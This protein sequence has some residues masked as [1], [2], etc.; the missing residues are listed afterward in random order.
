MI[1]TVATEPE[2]NPTAVTSFKL[3]AMIGTWGV[4]YHQGQRSRPHLKAGHM[5]A[6]DQRDQKRK[7]TLANRGRPHM[8]ALD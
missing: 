7:N 5:T 1:H 2:D 6:A 3:A 8:T 4:G